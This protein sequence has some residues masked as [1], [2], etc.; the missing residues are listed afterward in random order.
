MR[1]AQIHLGLLPIPP[2]GWGAVE[3]IVW[4][5]IQELRKKGHDVGIEYIND[6]EKNDY[7]IFHVHAWNHALMLKERG[8]PYVFSLHDHHTVIYGKESELYLR[9]LEAMKYAEVAIVHAKFLIDYFDGIPVYVPHGVDTN[10][11]TPSD[12]RNTNHSLL[13]VGNNGLFQ[14]KAFDR[15]GFRYAIEAAKQLDL[16][17]TVVGP[18]NN[19]ALFFEQNAD[20]SSYEKLNILYDLKDDEL[21]DVYDKSTLLIHATDIE[22]GHPPL[23]ILEAASCGLPV[24]TTDCAGDLYTIPISRD[25]SDIVDKLRETIKVYDLRSSL[26]FKSATNFSW[27]KIVDKLLS[28]YSYTKKVG[29]AKSALNV[30]NRVERI[31]M[32][33]KITINFV[34][35]A[36][37]EVTGNE[38]REYSVSFINGDTMKTIYETKIRNNNWA[39]ANIKYHVNWLIRITSDNGSVFEHK[40]N[41][42]DKRVLISFESSSLGDTIAWFPYVD[43]FRKKHGCKVI[44]STFHN[45]LFGKNYPE[46]EFVNPGTQVENLYALYRFGCFYELDSGSDFSHHRTDHRK[47]KLQEIATDILGLDFEEIRPKIWIEN[48]NKVESGDYVTLGIHST[49]QSKYWNNPNGWQEMVDYLNSKNI[50]TVHISQQVGEYMGNIPPVNVIDKTGNLSL[51]N[52]ITDILNSKMFIGISS[53]LS[54]VAWALGVPTLIISGCT[55]REHEP[56]DGILRVINENVCNSCFSKHFFDKGDWNW[57]PEHKGTDRQFECSKSISFDMV[58]SEIDKLIAG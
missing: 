19:N 2:N 6:I 44:V 37:V 24:L 16:P 4:E 51:Q 43:E 39:Q 5:Y 20:L 13:C 58:K 45:D 9:N 10:R 54:W 38:D 17:I 1:I 28:V 36:F 18:T 21:I 30:Y 22:A 57:C 46:I 33:N 47:L 35:G 26:S 41:C 31:K 14:D 55:E 29:M 12:K 53:G 49:A 7:D 32:E 48:T 56:K 42:K 3:K 15:K 52:R 11:Y 8:I 40:F 34:D 27:D 23:T 25:S 50:K